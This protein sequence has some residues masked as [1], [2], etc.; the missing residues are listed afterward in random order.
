MHLVVSPNQ[1]HNTC[2]GLG[3][4]PKRGD[5]EAFYPFFDAIFS[6]FC[7]TSYYI[8]LVATT[9]TWSSNRHDEL[10]KKNCGRFGNVPLLV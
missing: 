10:K 8:K 4:N 5:F 3:L 1:R 7:I 9:W 2:G 6:P